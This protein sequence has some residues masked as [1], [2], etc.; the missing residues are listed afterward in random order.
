MVGMFCFKEIPQSTSPARLNSG[1]GGSAQFITSI[2][3]ERDRE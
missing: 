2:S 1:P 3:A